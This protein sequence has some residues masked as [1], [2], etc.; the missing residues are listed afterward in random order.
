MSK[1]AGLSEGGY[2]HKLTIPDGLMPFCGDLERAFAEIRRMNGARLQEILDTEE[3]TILYQEVILG[4]ERRWDAM[5]KRRSEPKW[6]AW[7]VEITT[8]LPN[9]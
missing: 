4:I 8:D 2:T 1:K 5:M 7:K 6:M 3:S 9:N